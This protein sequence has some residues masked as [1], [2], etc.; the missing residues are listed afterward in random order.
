MYP[1]FRELLVNMLGNGI[2]FLLNCDQIILKCQSYIII[3]WLE[4]FSFEGTMEYSQND[5]SEQ[6]KTGIKENST[7]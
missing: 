3:S 6:N 4:T 2:A 5:D 7:I 1:L